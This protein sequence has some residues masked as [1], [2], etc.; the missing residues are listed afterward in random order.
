MLIIRRIDDEAKFHFYIVFFG[1]NI[2]IMKYYFISMV[3]VA[4]SFRFAVSWIF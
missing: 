4:I 2:L 3:I 1:L